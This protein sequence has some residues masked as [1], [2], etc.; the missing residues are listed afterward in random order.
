MRTWAKEH[1]DDEVSQMILKLDTSTISR[2]LMFF[3]PFEVQITDLESYQKNT[4]GEASHDIYK[5]Q[6]LQTAIQ[7]LFRP[8]IQ[9]L[10]TPKP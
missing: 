4:E 8:I 6:Q 1:R 7:R 2:N 9:N 5:K 10:Q 3:Y